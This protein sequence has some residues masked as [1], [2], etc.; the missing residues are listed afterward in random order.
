MPPFRQDLFLSLCG[1][2]KRG[3]CTLTLENR[4]HGS[5]SAFCS[6]PVE[7]IARQKQKRK[8]SPST[9]WREAERKREQRENRD[10][11]PLSCPSVVRLPAVTSPLFTPTPSTISAPFLFY[12]YIP[13]LRYPLCKRFARLW[14]ALT[15]RAQGM[16]LPP[17]PIEFCMQ[18]SGHSSM[19][20]LARKAGK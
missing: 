4:F 18:N 5:T 17:W 7:E 11:R 13:S 2:T 6:A 8:P 9:A 1:E 12:F 10:N 20:Q 15:N 19:E 16:T 14:R 3:R